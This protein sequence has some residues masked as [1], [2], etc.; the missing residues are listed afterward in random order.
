M[1]TKLETYIAERAVQIIIALAVVTALSLVA[2]AAALS[3]N[4]L[5]SSKM[6]A[7]DR[8][9]TV[10]D[11]RP[12]GGARTFYYI[13]GCE[14]TPAATEQEPTV[15][16]SEPMRMRQP[17]KK[18]SGWGP[19]DFDREIEAFDVTNQESDK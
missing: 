12:V 15:K 8:K 7:I 16:M 17:K 14:A 19:T 9:V 10:L 18:S 6:Q 5:L 4:S 1:K 11:E 13:Q 2:A 3:M